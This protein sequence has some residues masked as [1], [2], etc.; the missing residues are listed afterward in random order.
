M[1]ILKRAAAPGQEPPSPIKVPAG[2][3]TGR[4]CPAACV[5]KVD[6]GHS[7][8]ATGAHATPAAPVVTTRAA[9]TTTAA[10]AP[11]VTAA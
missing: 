6:A 9:P 8:R 1:I 7:Q 10:G 4:L 11:A 5:G 3:K 2:T